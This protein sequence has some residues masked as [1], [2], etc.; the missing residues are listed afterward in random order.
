MIRKRDGY[1]KSMGMESQRGRLTPMPKAMSNCSSLRF[2]LWRS[3]SA[4]GSDLISVIFHSPSETFSLLRTVVL[5]RMSNGG[6]GGG[7]TADIVMSEGGW[8]SL[9]SGSVFFLMSRCVDDGRL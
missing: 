7:G 6:G 2:P 8:K 5:V 4:G 9:E 1:G 3:G